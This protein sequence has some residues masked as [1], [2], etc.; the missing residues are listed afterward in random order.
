M[1]LVGLQCVEGLYWNTSI[2]GVLHVELPCFC[3]VQPSAV[4]HILMH[5]M[6]I[7]G[8]FFHVVGQQGLLFHCSGCVEVCKLSG[9][10]DHIW[11]C[12]HADLNH[13]CCCKRTNYMPK[14][15]QWQHQQ[16]DDILINC[17]A[18]LSISCQFMMSHLSLP[19]DQSSISTCNSWD[20]MH[21]LASSA[22]V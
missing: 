17:T 4:R 9:N 2:E 21:C 18:P 14:K 19:T 1:H 11:H 15:T 16:A 13:R 22:T 3:I 10:V 7:H 12:M 5:P 8:Q 6:F 20:N